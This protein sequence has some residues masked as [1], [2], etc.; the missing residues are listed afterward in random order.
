[1]NRND[2]WGHVNTTSLDDD[3]LGT[4]EKRKSR[5]HRMFALAYLVM[6]I[7]IF[8]YTKP[9]FESLHGSVLHAYLAGMAILYIAS[10]MLVAVPHALA[11]FYL[12]FTR[13]E[14]E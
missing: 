13:F 4:F 7:I 11:I 2:D 8:E 9:E 14:K 12:K 5:I 6:T 10:M 1:M 3:S